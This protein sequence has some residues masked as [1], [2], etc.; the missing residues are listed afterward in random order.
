[1]ANMD[2]LKCVKTFNISVR[3]KTCLK[4]MLKSI[5]LVICKKNS[6]RTRFEHRKFII[7]RRSAINEINPIKV[8]EC[9]FNGY[10]PKFAWNNFK[11]WPVDGV[12]LWCSAF[13]LILL[14][15]CSQREFKIR[16]TKS[17]SA[18]RQNLPASNAESKLGNL[19]AKTSRLM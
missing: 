18:K 7:N 1:M 16:R 11:F 13:R 6:T 2:V 12:S 19:A 5:Q 14:C 8:V 4:S 15:D 9:L 10:F 3:A 17:N